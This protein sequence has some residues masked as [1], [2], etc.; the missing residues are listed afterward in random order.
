LKIVFS[1]VSP[2][3]AL[4]VALRCVWN[5]STFLVVLTLPSFSRE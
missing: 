4:E 5:R 2:V 3:V 1:P